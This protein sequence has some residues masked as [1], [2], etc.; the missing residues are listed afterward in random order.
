M[1]IITCLFFVWCAF[2]A[3]AQ[4]KIAFV[5]LDSIVSKLPE[6]KSKLQIIESYGKQLQAQL[7]KKTAQFQQKQKQ[8]QETAASLS[9]ILLEEKKQE[10]EKLR[11]DIISMQQSSRE[12]F[13]KKQQEIFSPIYKK[14]NKMVADFAKVEKYDFIFVQKNTTNFLFPFAYWQENDNVTQ[15]ILEKM[16]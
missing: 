12:R 1:K 8:L 6:T 9:L 10:L 4:Q 7:E 13:D 14:V 16:K 3:F 11:G 2:P 5:N 15:A